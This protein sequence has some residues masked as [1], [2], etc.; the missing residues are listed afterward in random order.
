MHILSKNAQCISCLRKCSCLYDPK[1]GRKWNSSEKIYP[2]PL[3]ALVL[4]MQKKKKI[5]TVLLA[6]TSSLFLP[7]T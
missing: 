1:S 3:D 5:E 4:S 2:N 7:S 6:Q